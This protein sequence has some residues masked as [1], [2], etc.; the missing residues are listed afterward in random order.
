MTVRPASQPYGSRPRR[1]CRSPI[2]PVVTGGYLRAECRDQFRRYAVT[3]SRASLR[4][5]ADSM[6]ALPDDL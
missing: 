5:Y 4:R 3:A 6:A 1:P 2:Y